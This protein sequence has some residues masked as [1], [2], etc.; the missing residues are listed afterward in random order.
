MN[1]QIKKL[2]MKKENSLVKTILK[3]FWSKAIHGMPLKIYEIY[4]PSKIFVKFL[5]FI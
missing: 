4:F 2:N 3:L 5:I 1:K